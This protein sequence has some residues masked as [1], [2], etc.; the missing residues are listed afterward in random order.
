MAG[1][2][3]TFD[4][5]QVIVTCGGVPIT[6]FVDGTFIEIEKNSDDFT[7]HMGTDGIGSRARSADESGKITINLQ[8][9][10]L[11]NDVLSQLRLIDRLAPSGAPF[12]VMIKDLSGTSTMATGFAWV[13]K[14]PKW[15][16]GKEI[17]PRQWV[18]ECNEILVYVGGNFP[19]IV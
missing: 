4:P 18:L 5:R 7:L 12:P 10:S 17:S 9:T 11:S 3:Y 6:G 1:E 19:S 13:R 15:E 14:Q 16:D 2:L 8:R